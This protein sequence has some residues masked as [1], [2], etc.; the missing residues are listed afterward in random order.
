MGNE[1]APRMFGALF[2]SCGKHPLHPHSRRRDLGE[3]ERNACTTLTR[4]PMLVVS[5]GARSFSVA[6]SCS[7]DVFIKLNLELKAQNPP[8]RNPK[9][10]FATK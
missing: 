4:V 9:T 6:Q 2:V 3:D 7:K 1:K 8:K 10:P 5:A